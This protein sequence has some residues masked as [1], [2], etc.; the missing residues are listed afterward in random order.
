MLRCDKDCQSIKRV[1]P[2]FLPFQFHLKSATSD[3]RT[4]GR[5]YKVSHRAIVILSQ[6]YHLPTI[7]KYMEHKVTTSAR[8]CPVAVPDAVAPYS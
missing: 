6:L 5:R 7:P 3:T 1:K 2:R 8:G 4:P